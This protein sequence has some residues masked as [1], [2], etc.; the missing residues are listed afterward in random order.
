MDNRTSKLDDGVWRVEVAPW[1][2]A[3]V[4]AADGAGD[5]DG[6]TLVDCGT[7]S[8]GPRLVRSIRMLGFAPTA[9]DNIVLT[10]WHA[11]H[12]G[13]AARFASSSAA[14]AIHVGPADAPAVRGQDP[15]PHQTAAPGEVSRLGR[16]LSRV[17]TPGPAVPEVQLLDEGVVL[18]WANGAR[19]LATPG[20]TAGSISL[21]TPGGVLIAGD[22]VMNVGR[23][24]R[25]IGPFRSARSSEAATLERLAGEEFDILA[26]GHGPPLITGAGRQLQ[27]LAQRAS[28]R[29]PPPT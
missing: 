21:L 9:V 10:H 2:N 17:A 13:S 11:D 3:Y 18:D 28:R 14:P 22:V 24:V 1:T 16:L 25:G 23:L 19:V 5:A 29:Q 20:H 6:L 4:L 27:R 12:M 8:S 7:T 26:V 15:R